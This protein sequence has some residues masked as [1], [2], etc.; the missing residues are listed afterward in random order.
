MCLRPVNVN[1]PFYET[2][3]FLIR[4]KTLFNIKYGFLT[5]KF[6]NAEFIQLHDITG[7]I[8]PRWNKKLQSTLFPGWSHSGEHSGT[9]HLF[10]EF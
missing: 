1:C 8:I 7:E 5:F 4:I 6:S 2:F 10:D 9:S 3:F